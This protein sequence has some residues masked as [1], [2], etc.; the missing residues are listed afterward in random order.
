M[1]NNHILSEYTVYNLLA[2]TSLNAVTMQQI[3]LPQLYDIEMTD[4][5][6]VP[7]RQLVHLS[8]NACCKAAMLQ[9]L[10]VLQANRFC[11]HGVTS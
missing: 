6:A 9:A 7:V 2:F 4:S 8:C 11:V 1:D 10:V 3:T 5:N